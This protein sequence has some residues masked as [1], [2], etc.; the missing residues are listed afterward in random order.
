[1][2]CTNV[3]HY[4][5]DFGC[6]LG[7]ADSICCY[8]IHHFHLSSQI[9]GQFCFCIAET[10]F[11]PS[12]Y[13]YFCVRGIVQSPFLI[14]QDRIFI[15]FS[16]LQDSD[17]GEQERG[18]CKSSVSP[19]RCG[20]ASRAESNGWRSPVQCLNKGDYFSKWDGVSGLIRK[21]VLVQR[22]PFLWRPW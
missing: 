17:R 5:A 4:L 22:N 16:V 7:K 1:M 13:V 20:K 11:S 2:W 12:Q 18:L 21:S 9:N 6:L 19:F 10:L 15:L 14:C 3:E 8:C